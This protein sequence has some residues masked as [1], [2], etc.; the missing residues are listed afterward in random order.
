MNPLDSLGKE[1]KTLLF[2]KQII[3]KVISVFSNFLNSL[4]LKV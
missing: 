3:F 4:Y 2:K 1:S